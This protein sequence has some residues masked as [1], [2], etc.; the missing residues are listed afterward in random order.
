MKRRK[1]TQEE[2]FGLTTTVGA[3]IFL[4]LIAILIITRPVED[5]RIAFI[6]ITLGEFRDGTLAEFSQEQNPVVATRPRPT[7][8]QA[9]IPR[10]EPVREQQEQ[11]ERQETAKPVELPEQTQD[12]QEEVVATP[13]TRQIDPTVVIREENREEQ[14]VRPETPVREAETEREGALTSGDIRGRTGNIEADQGTGRDL[15]R[16]APFTLEWEGD[17]ERAPLQQPLPNYT[18]EVEAIITVRFEVR[19]D[20]T[21]GRITPIRRMSPELEREVNRTLRSWRF[22]RLPGGLPQEPQFGVI[23]FRFV[24]E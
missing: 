15:D 10:P 21:V 22:S 16:S 2:K 4:I 8:V 23:T 18:A 12:I 7:P 14:V 20:G 17:I 11:V 1:L 6:E 3:H 19:P 5:D 13:E 9:E 24:L